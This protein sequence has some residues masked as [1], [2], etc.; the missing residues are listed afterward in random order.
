MFSLSWFGFFSG[1]AM[2][3]LRNGD[4][5]RTISRYLGDWGLGSTKKKRKKD[6]P[7]ERKQPPNPQPPKKGKGKLRMAI[8]ALRDGYVIPSLSGVFPFLKAGS[9]DVFALWVGCVSV[10]TPHQYACISGRGL[11]PQRQ[12]GQDTCHL[13]DTFFRVQLPWAKA[14]GKNDE[15]GTGEASPSSCDE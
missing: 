11:S 9:Y 3:P 2:L 6:P 5:V 4:G 12:K 15:N 8:R 13:R 7:N 14:R 1:F 10:E